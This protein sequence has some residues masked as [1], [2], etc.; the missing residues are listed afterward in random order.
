MK[1]GTCGFC[2]SQS[3]IFKNL[4][5][6]ELQNTFYD[7]V[8][9][10]TLKSYRIKAPENFEFTIKSIQI[11]THEKNSPTYRRFKS[12]D[13]NTDN[14]GN[15]R[16][17]KDTEL[18]MEKMF[19]YANI[20]KAKIIIFQSP[21]SFGESENNVKNIFEF[22]TTFKKQGILFGWEPRGKWSDSTLLKIFSDFNIIHV[23][24]P[25]KQKPIY[26]DFNYFR[27]HGI[28]SYNYIFTE[29]DLKNLKDMTKVN[30]YVLFNN[31]HMCNDALKFRGMINDL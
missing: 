7:F 26:G 4:D 9:E 5:V 30:D 12:Y 3:F 22:F 1:I 13:L 21:P 19:E 16:V 31:V 11:I 14:F 10:E 28:G 18:A 20:L 27:L 2:R 15:F 25:F 23:V 24:D 29:K 8:K 17:N 6:V